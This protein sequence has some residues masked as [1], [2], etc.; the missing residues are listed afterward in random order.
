MALAIS[1]GDRPE[2]KIPCSHRGHPSGNPSPPTSFAE[3][4]DYEDYDRNVF[5]IM[6]WWQAK[7]RDAFPDNLQK[8]RGP[9]IHMGYPSGEKNMARQCPQKAL[10]PIHFSDTTS[11]TNNVLVLY[12]TF[13]HLSFLSMHLPLSA[14]PQ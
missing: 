6:H 8:D 14:L 12:D 9:M 3:I 5:P 4:D 11:S 7:F 10:K 2:R 1:T 13:P